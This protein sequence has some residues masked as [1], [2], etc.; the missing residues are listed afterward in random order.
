LKW[1]LGQLV[2]GDMRRF[3]TIDVGSNSVL[4][5]VSERI[6]SSF[7]TILDSLQVCRLGEGLNQRGKF[8][9]QAMVR[10]M[11]AICEFKRLADE[12]GASEIAAVGTMAMRSASNSEQFVSMV[13]SKCGV[14]IEVLTG[15]EEARFAYLGARDVIQDKRQRVVIIDVGGGSTEFIHGSGQ[16]I[17]RSYSL[18][19][20]ALHLT[21]QFLRHD[22]PL[23][24]EINSIKNYLSSVFAHI[25]RQKNI[26]LVGVG[27]TITT[28]SAVNLR[29]RTYD[30]NLIHGSVLNRQDIESQ[31]ERF[32]S[33][34]REQRCKL[35]GLQ[36]NRAGIILAGAIVVEQVM[37]KMHKRNLVVSAR[38]VRH[39]LMLDRFGEMKR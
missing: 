32:A 2:V 3:A 22:P 28:L 15:Q 36:A 7:V 4:V 20:G 31:I 19:V 27:G 6:K 12:Y 38:G 25:E 17:N 35:P 18:N 10:T 16:E 23:A 24:E 13:R 37:D 21:E 1:L 33:M 34:N 26:R 11:T 8:S 39:G 9:E 14:Q 30:P 5:L 29:M